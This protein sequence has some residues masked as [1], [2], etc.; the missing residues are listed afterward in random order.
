M[1]SDTIF[2][3]AAGTLLIHIAQKKTS[4]MQLLFSVLKRKCLE[5]TSLSSAPWHVWGA[6]ALCYRTLKTMMVELQFRLVDV[7]P[8]EMSVQYCQFPSLQRTKGVSY[9]TSI[10]NQ[11]SNIHYL[12]YWNEPQGYFKAPEKLTWTMMYEKSV[13]VWIVEHVGV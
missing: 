9:Y 2:N 12:V 7:L 10:L 4:L 11:P 1:F 8:S 3:V 13:S 5:F 6:F